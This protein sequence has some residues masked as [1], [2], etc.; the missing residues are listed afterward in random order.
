MIYKNK[1]HLL[2]DLLG[3]IEIKGKRAFIV[4]E[5]RI[6]DEL[7]DNLV[8]NSL[9]NEDIKIKD[10]SRWFIREIGYNLGIIPSSIYPFYVEKGNGKFPNM[11]IPAINIRGLTYDTARAVFSAS[12][13]CN[14]SLFIFEIARSEM[15]YTEQSADEYATMIIAASIKEGISLP[16]FIQ[17]DHFQIRK[18]IPNDIKN[19]KRLIENVIDAGFYNIDLDTSVLVDLSFPSI[20]EQQRENFTK[21]AIL[22][23]YIRAIEPKGINISLGG[24]IGEIGGKNSTEEELREYM[25]GYLE[26][27]K[28][29]GIDIGISKIAVQT[30][31][32]HGGIPLPGGGVASVKLD[33]E[34]L[35]RLGRVS[36]EYHLAGC[37]QHGASTLPIEL[38]SKFCEADVCEVHLATEFQNIL[39]N[40]IPD[41]LRERI[42][43]YLK[44][45]FKK[46][47]KDGETETQFLYKTRKK[48]LGVFKK[49]LFELSDEVK[50]NIRETL[51]EKFVNIFK[52]L[53]V[54]NTDTRE[55][56]SLFKPI[57]YPK[58]LGL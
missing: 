8:Y 17:A 55:I 9:F 5:K 57:Y 48:G 13:I 4:D 26:E 25:N 50:R 34:T 16:V 47:A 20:K 23:K 28:K 18:N 35:E 27:I 12:K 11:T 43:S 39:Y 58:P 52:M 29:M 49:E 45:S 32:V 21:A 56:T 38:F 53:K 42:Y 15:E 22:T 46:E 37:V 54:D 24:E 2:N 19:L 6:R 40:L 14:A 41:K 30:G 36:K 33:F 44:E 31:T 10:A 7:I 51:K 1:E 3:K